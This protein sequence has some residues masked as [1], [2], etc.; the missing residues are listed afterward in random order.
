VNRIVFVIMAIS[1]AGAA[2]S[3]NE[4]SAP[5]K[6]TSAAAQPTQPAPTAPAPLEP[7][8]PTAPLPPATL[9]EVNLTLT[10]TGGGIEELTGGYGPGFFGRRLVDGKVDPPWKVPATWTWNNRAWPKYPTEAVFSFF[11]RQSALVGALSIV[12][13]EKT[14]AELPNETSA[15]P[16]DVE[17]GLRW[18][19]RPPGSVR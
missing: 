4:E 12:L 15:A 1:M 16:K 18:R 11:N 10:D 13:P 14:T 19:A 8:E 2:C 9:T 6:A 7:G 5:A 3:R 17:S